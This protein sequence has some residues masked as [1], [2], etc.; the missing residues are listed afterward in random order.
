MTRILKSGGSFAFGAAR[1]A[2]NASSFAK[3]RQRIASTTTWGR[4]CATLKP[5][6]SRYAATACVPV[7]PKPAPMTTGRRIGSIGGAPV[8]SRYPT[9]FR[10]VFRSRRQSAGSLRSRF[11]QLP[12]TA[13]W[14]RSHESFASA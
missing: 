12:P 7:C 14:R 13:L 6:S 2:S 5:S 1:N 8:S 3:L 10:V 4:L 11:R 9:A